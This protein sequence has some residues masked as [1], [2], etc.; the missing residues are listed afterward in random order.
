MSLI[1]QTVES[2][3]A[4]KNSEKLRYDAALE[5]AKRNYW[6][7]N[8]IAIMTDMVNDSESGINEDLRGRVSEMISGIETKMSEIEEK[9]KL[10]ASIVEAYES[11]YNKI[12][13]G[14]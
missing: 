12:M 4:I 8:I 7:Q 13:R 1:R 3:K 5:K 10:Q 11:N 6:K 2:L 14:E 9:A